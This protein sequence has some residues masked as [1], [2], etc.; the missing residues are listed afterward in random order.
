MLTEAD[1]NRAAAATGF[2]AEPLEKVIR[3]L[4]MLDGLRSHPFLKPRI[5]LKGGGGTRMGRKRSCC[6][7]SRRRRGRRTDAGGVVA[8]GARGR[9]RPQPVVL[10]QGD[11]HK[12]RRVGRNRLISRHWGSLFPGLRCGSRDSIS[13]SSGSFSPIISRLEQNSRIEGY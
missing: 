13:A 12:P 4:E 6:R 11:R 9:E 1:V 3:L 5:A 8:L 2:R 10:G 7:L